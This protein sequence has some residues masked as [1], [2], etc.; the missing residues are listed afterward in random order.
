MI[1]TLQELQKHVDVAIVG[2]SDLKKIE[3]QLTPEGI[4]KANSVLGFVDYTFSENG[5]KSFKKK[6]LIA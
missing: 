5:L 2:G 3:E 1:E 6:E 4:F